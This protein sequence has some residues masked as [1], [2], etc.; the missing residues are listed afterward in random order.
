[1]R[2]LAT[3]AGGSVEL[4]CTGRCSQRGREARRGTEL[5]PA[6][7]PEAAAGR[8]AELLVSDVVNTGG[9]AMAAGLEV[10]EAAPELGKPA[11]GAV[12][13]SRGSGGSSRFMSAR[14]T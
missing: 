2:T 12:V 11:T 9:D 3:Q 8:G 1:M 13:I 4:R 10:E 6:C 14:E 7:S 5:A